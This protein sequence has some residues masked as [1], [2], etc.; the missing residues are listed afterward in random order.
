MA[1]T[2]DQRSTEGFTTSG[3]YASAS[4]GVLDALQI[5]E[6]TK[7]RRLAFLRRTWAKG[8]ASGDTGPT[9]FAGIKGKGA[10]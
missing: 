10:N 6:S 3:R 8:E 9:D 2:K 4:E 5:M 7:E 1:T